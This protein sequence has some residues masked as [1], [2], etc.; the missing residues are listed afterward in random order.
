M[1]TYTGTTGDDTL[2]GSSSSDVIR[3]DD[4]NDTLNG[5]AG[6]D[7]ITSGM[8]T[9]TVD[10]GDGNDIIHGHS[11]SESTIASI[12]SANPTVVWNASTNSFYQYVTSTAIWTAAKT[13]AEGTSLNGIAGHLAVITS[14]T[15][16]TYLVS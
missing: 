2:T 6:D 9:D 15:E 14:A 16:Q 11:I 3:G 7:F 12:L 13:A 5:D 1:A 10:G 4:G 8:G